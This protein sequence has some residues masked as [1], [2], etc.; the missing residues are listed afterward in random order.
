MGFGDGGH[1]KRFLGRPNATLG[2]QSTDC[3]AEGGICEPIAGGHRSPVG[4]ERRVGDDRGLAIGRSDD[5]LERPG[6][7]ATELSGDDGEIVL[8]DRGGSV[9]SVRADA[10]GRCFSVPD[11]H[12]RPVQPG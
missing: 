3:V 9:P 10:I 7:Q 5:H 8:A 4:Q 6:G 1:W 2:L 11:S 12:A